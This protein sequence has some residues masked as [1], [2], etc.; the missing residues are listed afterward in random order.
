MRWELKSGYDCTTKNCHTA[1][2]MCIYTLMQA[3]KAGPLLR[4]KRSCTQLRVHKWQVAK[5]GDK[6]IHAS[7][8]L[9]VVVLRR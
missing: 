2:Y 5:D 6:D 4:Q 9:F 8:S 1:V 7:V 3:L